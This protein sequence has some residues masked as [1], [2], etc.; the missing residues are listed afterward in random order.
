MP[1]Q[2]FAIMREAVIVQLVKVLEPQPWSHALWLEGAD[3]LGAV[4]AYSDLD[5]WLD[6]EDAQIETAIRTVDQALQA[7]GA[8]DM[9]ETYVHAHPQIRQKIYHLQG[10]SPY[11]LI[12]FCWQ[13]HSR[14]AA[15]S[16]FLRGDRVETVQILF[17]KSPVIHFLEPEQIEPVQMDAA[18]L[19]EMQQ[20]LRQ[21]C[22][23]QKYVL[24]EQFPEAL[25]YYN[26]YLI[27]PLVYLLRLR[28]TP[29]YPDMHLIHISRHIPTQDLQ[30]LESLLR[31]GSLADLGRNIPAAVRWFHELEDE[32]GL[33]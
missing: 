15:E 31:N 5:C 20:R 12:D 25:V 33:A 28:Y 21:S 1:E 9:N 10:S 27:E 8:L 16:Q 3:A 7:L 19:N 2:G 14:P 24:R 11:L 17:E 26:K 13:L 4:D 29:R 32:L 22:R 6:V 18:T 30:R 23:P